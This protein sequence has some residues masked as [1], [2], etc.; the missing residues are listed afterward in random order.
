MD[1]W[2]VLG[3]LVPSGGVVM[4]GKWVKEQWEQ[5]PY[6]EVRATRASDPPGTVDLA[7]RVSNRSA[8]P[9]QVDSYRVV[10][11]ENGPLESG[12]PR[13]WR[14]PFDPFGVRHLAQRIEPLLPSATGWPF[15]ECRDR[16]DVG[17][18]IIGDLEV[19]I[20]VKWRRF[21]RTHDHMQVRVPVKPPTGGEG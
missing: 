14:E 1:W 4:L 5:A 7:I 3:I 9:L 13:R 8:A 6:V 18:P 15:V 16:V 21:G 10:L 2:T 20:R 11:P 12:Q 19:S 17:F